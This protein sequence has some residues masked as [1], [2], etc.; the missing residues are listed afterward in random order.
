MLLWLLSELYER[1]PEVGDLDQ[2]KLVFFFDEAHLLF[3]EAPKVLVERIELVVVRDVQFFRINGS[4]VGGL[5]GLLIH[6]LSVL[7]T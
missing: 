4:V 7:V 1:L 6:A 3:D 5:V 2:P